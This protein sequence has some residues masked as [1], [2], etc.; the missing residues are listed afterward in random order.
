MTTLQRLLDDPTTAGVWNLVPDRSSIGF[1]NR[2]LWGLVKV[3]GEFTEVTGDGQ[4]TPKGAVFG[5]LDI[6]AASVR[7]GIRRRDEHLRSP[8]F[9]DTEKFPEISVVVTAVQP[10]GGN[11]AD[12][13]ATLAIRDTTL[14]LHLSATIDRLGDG[15]VRISAQATID[16][17]KWGVSG[18]MAGM[19]PPMSSLHADTV[20][21][22]AP[23]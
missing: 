19:L 3:N 7:T 21:A 15:G 8:D 20:F 11:T 6:Q 5:R 14:P 13:R 10:T 18:N 4:I 9:F 22:K 1:T 17:T 16:R 12:L 2:T 23:D